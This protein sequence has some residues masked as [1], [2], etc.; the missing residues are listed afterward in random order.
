MAQRV[1]IWRSVFEAFSIPEVKKRALFTLGAII[2]FRIGVAIP[3]PGVNL[4]AFAD[5]FRGF[6]GGIFGL[7]NMFSGGALQRF[8]LFAL[9]VVPYINASIIFSLLV[10]VIPRLKELQQQGDE[11]RKVITRWTRYATV[12][13]AMIQALGYSYIIVNQGLLKPGQPIIQFFITSLIAMVAGTIFL[14]WLGERI[15]E[16]GI[17]NGISMII[18]LGIISRF[19]QYVRDTWLAI[20]TGTTSPFW[21]LALIIVFIGVTAGIV[22]VQLGARK[23]E[24]QYAKRI[25]Q[26]RVYGGQSTYL[27]I[28]VNQGGVIP[29]IFASAL[30][31]LPLTVVNFIP[32]LQWVQAYIGEGSPAYLFAYALLIIFFTY[33]YSAIIFDPRDVADNLR[34]WGGF[35]PG[36]RP[37]RYTSDYISRIINRVL[38]IGALFLTAVAILPYIIIGASGISGIWIGGTSLLIVVGVGVDM[39]K[40]IEAHMVE[41]Q[42]E[43]LIKKGAIL[44]RRI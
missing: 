36:I 7:L 15:T 14:M 4:E 31:A 6:G 32:N 1:S 27:P 12:L 22:M 28:A 37:G 24:V 8:S 26:G 5:F 16:N 19:P 18:M 44:G 3:V 2:V 35:I 39:M 10:P 11:G 29:I 41:R 42:Y 20:S 38:L 33:F 13:L 25:V 21:A 43:S 40:Q 23:L 30:L 34:K 9:G 17:G